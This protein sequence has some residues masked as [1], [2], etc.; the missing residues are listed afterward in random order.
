MIMGISYDEF[1]RY[2][3]II[4]VLLIIIMLVGFVLYKMH[5]SKQ[6]NRENEK[7]AGF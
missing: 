2:S 3:I 6:Y 5:E 7:D 1:W 4:F